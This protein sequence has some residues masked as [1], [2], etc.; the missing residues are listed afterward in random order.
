MALYFISTALLVDKRLGSV[1]GN[2]IPSGQKVLMEEYN[3]PRQF[4]VK[5]LANVFHWRFDLLPLKSATI[6]HSISG[7]FTTVIL[8]AI[9]VL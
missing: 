5:R 7:S 8:L 3:I 6:I 2:S 1:L 4:K 9:T